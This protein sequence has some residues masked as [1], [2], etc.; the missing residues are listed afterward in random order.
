M[1]VWVHRY[2]AGICESYA[3]SSIKLLIFLAPILHSGNDDL[4]CDRSSLWFPGQ[5]KPLWCFFAYF[6]KGRISIVGFTS[7]IFLACLAEALRVAFSRSIC[8][9]TMVES[10]S[11]T[12]CAQLCCSIWRSACFLIAVDFRFFPTDE[13]AG[14]A[15]HY[16]WALGREDNV[17]LGRILT[18]KEFS[19][20]L[21]GWDEFLGTLL[22]S[23]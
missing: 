3:G 18:T 4:C 2:I 21:C 16:E 13:L 6:D 23:N 19:L 14:R 8:S 5:W 11:A 15:I 7:Y 17:C 20:S 10:I 22:W 1:L 12:P 9:L